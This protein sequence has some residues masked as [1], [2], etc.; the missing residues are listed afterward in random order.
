MP[1]TSPAVLLERE[2]MLGQMLPGIFQRDLPPLLDIKRLARVNL[3][4]TTL[5]GP[6]LAEAETH[7]NFYRPA[8]LD[9]A[10][11]FTWR[12]SGTLDTVVRQWR[13]DFLRHLGPSELNC[14][15]MV[16]IVDLEATGGRLPMPEPGVTAETT[17]PTEPAP[18][19]EPPALLPK[20]ARS[21]QD[22]LHHVEDHS[23]AASPA[24]P[25]VTQVRREKSD[26]GI[27]LPGNL[28][29]DYFGFERM[30]FNNTPDT[31]FFFPTPKHQEA[32]SRLIWAI[33]ERKGFVMISGEIGAG[34][35]TLCRTLLAQLPSSI[36][37]ALITHT[38]LDGKQ[39]VRAIAEDLGVNTHNLSE[40]EIMQHLTEFLIQ[41]LA[42]GHTVCI[43]IDEA[44]N[45]SPAA[46]EEVRMISNI[47]TEQEKLVQLILLGQPELRDKL[48]LAEMAQLRQRIAS[49]YHLEPLDKRETVGYITH[50]LHLASPTQPLD[51]RKNAMTEVYR[52]SGGVPRLVNTLCDNA[53]LT[54]F[55]HDQ[56]VVTP[57][58]VREA[59]H[60]LELEPKRGG[61]AEFFKLW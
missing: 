11:E 52:F 53:L 4:V 24:A 59:A 33:S 12:S 10:P 43:I 30:P 42:E 18:Q 50:R 9:R 2:G 32:L 27:P 49:A 17:A 41:Q 14:Q 1:L 36:K 56:R 25:P 44:Q 58:M 16:R 37:T 31:H 45:L 21:V 19:R 39:L 20:E 15:V 3:I 5:L 48:R 55:T 7:G 23:D 61:I 57:Q 22:W 38:H 26:G 6:R 8:R 60:D 34:K 35:S 47:E 51:F 28:Y 46:L 40:Y 13:L 29:Q 54:A